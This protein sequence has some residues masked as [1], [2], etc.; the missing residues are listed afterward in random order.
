M[1]EIDSLRCGYGDREVISGISLRIETGEMVGILGPNG[2]GKTTLV[3][4]LAGAIPV[5]SGTIRLNGHDATTKSARW[6]A[7]QIASVPQK[8]EA[9]FPFR[10]LGVVLMGRYPYLDGW[11]GYSEDDMNAA[12]DAMEQTSILH[13][14][15]RS[16]REVS[17]GEAQTVTIARALAQQTPIILL[18]E[19]TANLDVSRKIEVFDMLVGKNR[20]G[21]T[22]MCVMHDLNLAALYCKRLIFLK[23]GKVVCDGKTEEVFSDDT[24]THIYETEVRVCP[25]PVSGIPQAHF[26]PRG[27]RGVRVDALLAGAGTQRG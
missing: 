15:S 1:I 9:S 17:G 13:L 6:T 14:S 24:L 23:N 7:R 27:M 3:L 26:V 11:G 25:H 19:A 10:C 20:E 22:L 8:A 2:S 12:L 16:F 4:A 5:I 18:D 21:A